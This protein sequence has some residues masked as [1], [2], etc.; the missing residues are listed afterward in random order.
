MNIRLQSLLLF[1]LFALAHL[2]AQQE[3]HCKT[4]IIERTVDENGN[5]ISESTRYEYEEGTLPGFDLP[6]TFDLDGL[7]FGDLF[8][9][10]DFLKNA[11]DRPTIGVTLD[12]QRGVGK[13]SDVTRGSGADESD[14]RVGDEII[15]IENI[16]V[17]SIQDIQEILGDKEVGDRI[18]VVIFRDGEEIVKK[19]GLKGSSNNPFFFNFS[20]E[21]GEIMDL[22]SELFE[23]FFG[24]IEG[25][26]QIE[27]NLDGLNLG[28]RHPN[29]NDPLG[30][31]ERATLGVFI[32]DIGVLNS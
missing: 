31:S 28:D 13:V 9:E 11:E 21:G 12:F 7:G 15:S 23:R 26:D 6:G 1:Y 18:R 3:E 25:W 8:Q 32:D 27:K 17:A 4:K 14:I 30:I 19:V 29:Q 24:D 20:E 5:I 16:A 22:Q 10:H 2:H